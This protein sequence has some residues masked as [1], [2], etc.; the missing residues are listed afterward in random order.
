MRE[1]FRLQNFEPVE[2]G[3]Q[4][5]GGVR[6]GRHRVVG[7]NLSVIGEGPVRRRELQVIHLQ[8]A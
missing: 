3:E 4:V 1:E 6:N 7:M 8:V 2:L 5:G